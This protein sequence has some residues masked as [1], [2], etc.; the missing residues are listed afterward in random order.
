MKPQTVTDQLD[1]WTLLKGKTQSF[2]PLEFWVGFEHYNV[3]WAQK[4]AGRLDFSCTGLIVLWKWV[5][6]M[7][8]HFRFR[9]CL[10]LY[11]VSRGS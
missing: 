6:M 3:E 4:P 11:R 9:K 8:I 7:R 5:D 2:D 10:F 1:N